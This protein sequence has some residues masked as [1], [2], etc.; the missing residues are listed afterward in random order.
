MICKCTNKLLVMLKHTRP[1]NLAKI[2]I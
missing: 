1:I 2:V